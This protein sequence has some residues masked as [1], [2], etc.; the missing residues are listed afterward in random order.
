MEDTASDKDLD[1]S[2]TKMSKFKGTATYLTKFK[3]EW[4]KEL[5]LSRI[6][7]NSDPYTGIQCFLM[8]STWTI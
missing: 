2:P 1:V 8:V 6:D 5:H 7:W 3:N 4:R